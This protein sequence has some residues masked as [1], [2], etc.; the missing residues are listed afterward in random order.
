MRELLGFKRF[1]PLGGLTRCP[2]S[3]TDFQAD[4]GASLSRSFGEH[5]A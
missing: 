3:I 5:C 2:R 4:G 1:S